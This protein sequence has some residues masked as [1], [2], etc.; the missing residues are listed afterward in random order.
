[1]RDFATL[2]ALLLCFAVPAMAETVV[3]SSEDTLRAALDAASQGEGATSIEIGGDSDIRISA[4]LVYAGRAPLELRGNGQTVLTD[5]NMTLLHV[6]EGADLTVSGLS[7][8]GPG[9]YAITAR[10]E[11]SAGKGIFVDLRDDQT[12]EVTVALDGVTVEGVSGH[13]IHISDC[14]HADDCGDGGSDASIRVALNAVTV[15]DVGNG[16]FDADGL[17]VDER[18]AGDIWFEATRSLFANIGADGVEL[19]EGQDGSVIV[20]VSD[21][22]FNTNG[23]YCDPA[24]LAAFVPSP[25]EAE[26]DQGAR[27]EADIPGPVTGTPDDACIER[28]VDLHDDGSVEFYEFGIDVDDGFDVDEAGQGHIIA[29]LNGTSIRENLGQGLDFDEEDA[30]S[31]VLRVEDGVFQSNI[32][33]GIKLS[34]ED[35]GDVLAILSGVFALSNG[36]KG[37]VFEEED[38]GDATV[39]VLFSTTRDNGDGDD[40]GLEV[41]EDDAGEGVL[42]LHQSTIADGFDA[43][44]VDLR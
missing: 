39:S 37:A 26:F 10:P 36:G 4:P 24:V 33:D 12:G 35:A 14:D 41:D 38:D 29:T 25:D 6:T 16:S 3:V 22:Q 42:M 19:D 17:R 20:N 43:D 13:G 31:I 23:A 7:F 9:G 34:E 30:G 15:R 5:Q 40:T 28:E 11:G 2:T 8:R 32:D 27:A 1:M 18:G 44:N 21:T